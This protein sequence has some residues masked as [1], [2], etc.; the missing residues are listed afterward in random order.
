M[1]KKPSKEH[2][3]EIEKSIDQALSG[4]DLLL[5]GDMERATMKINARPPRPK[6]DK[7]AAAS[8]RSADKSEVAADSDRAADITK[9]D[10]P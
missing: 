1:L 3:A 6:P 8:D 10:T 5:D 4:L 9:V 7:P 2:L